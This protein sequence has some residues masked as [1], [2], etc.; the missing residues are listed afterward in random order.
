MLHFNA[1]TYCTVLYSCSE[2]D[3]FAWQRSVT[4]VLALVLDVA[5]LLPDVVVDDLVVRRH[6][7]DELEELFPQL[8]RLHLE[9][10]GVL[11]DRPGSKRS[12]KPY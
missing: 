11:R 2:L 1:I 5:E 12:P 8:V 7:V 6:L 3:A 10:L 4:G 9:E